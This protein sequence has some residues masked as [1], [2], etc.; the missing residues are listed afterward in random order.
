MEPRSEEINSGTT[1]YFIFS[2]PSGDEIKIIYDNKNNETIILFSEQRYVLQRA[3]SGPGTC[4]TNDDESIVFW[5]HHGEATLEVDGEIVAQSCSLD[6]GI[7]YWKECRSGDMIFK[8]PESL[9]EKYISLQQWPPEIKIIANKNDWPLGIVIEKGELKCQTTPE[10]SNFSKRFYQQDISGRTYC[11]NAE[12]EG[13]A[14]SVF[15][16]YTYYTVYK[17]NLVSIKKEKGSGLE[18]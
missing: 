8:V 17:R 10:E 16:D 4:Y 3:I 12:S 2:C 11:I 5:E 7:D 13:A 9:E 6:E 18:L 1:D 14:G 15:T